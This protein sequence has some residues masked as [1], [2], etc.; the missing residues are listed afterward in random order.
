[1]TKALP[2]LCCRFLRVNG[3]I[4]AKWVSGQHYLFQ[5][6]KLDTSGHVAKRT[7]SCRECSS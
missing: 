6:P 1:M 2:I 5:Q 7:I 3:M 4:L